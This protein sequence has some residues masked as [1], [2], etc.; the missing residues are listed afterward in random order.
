L[1]T[2]NIPGSIRGNIALL[3]KGANVRIA[4]LDNSAEAEKHDTALCSVISNVTQA[5][6]GIE[7]DYRI[8][9]GRQVASLRLAFQR[10][11]Q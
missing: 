5:L 11:E 8:V 3:A 4:V 6:E 7:Q 1:S 10:F 2:E 9:M